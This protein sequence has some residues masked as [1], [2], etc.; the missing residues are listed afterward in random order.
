MK[1]LIL[2]RVLNLLLWLSACFLLGSGL[3]LKWNF[4]HG[5][6]SGRAMMLG[7]SKHEWGDIH[8]WVGIGFAVLV[9]AHLYLAWP[10]LK[11]AAAGK[12]RLWAV[13]AGLAVGLAIPVTLVL[14][15]VQST[16]GF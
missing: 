8:A 14:L 1:K 7:L 2:R 4:P 3:A 12:K 6:R 11:N 13:F 15:P 16:V 10:W 5:P 9:A